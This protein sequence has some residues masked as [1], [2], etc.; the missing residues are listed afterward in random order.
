MI[1]AEPGDAALPDR[2][3]ALPEL[4]FWQV[5]SCGL[6]RVCWRRSCGG[7]EGR[8]RFIVDGLFG[9]LGFGGW[10]LFVPELPEQ[11]QRQGWLGQ[12]ADR[13]GSPDVG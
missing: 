13:F 10:M 5:V 3:A 12:D 11:L 9:L 8:V 6:R 2:A 7:F 4:G 1:N